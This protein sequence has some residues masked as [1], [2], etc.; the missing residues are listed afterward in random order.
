[1]RWGMTEEECRSCRFL[2]AAMSETGKQ[3]RLLR[4]EEF[5]LE[6]QR[7]VLDRQQ[8]LWLLLFAIKNEIPTDQF[9]SLHILPDKAEVTVPSSR[10]G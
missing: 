5:R 4:A 8:N 1:M 6:Q 9:R 2:I 3:L 7:L 10:G